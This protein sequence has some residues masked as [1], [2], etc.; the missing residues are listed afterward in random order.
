MEVHRGV[1]SAALL[2]LLHFSVCLSSNQPKNE[3]LFEGALCEAET[4]RISP[5]NFWQLQE[6]I[7]S[8]KHIILNGVEFRVYGSNGFV[9]IE[10]VSNLT[11]S[12]GESG[13]LIECSPQSIFGLHLKNTTNVTL[14][15]LR[16]RNCGS[17]IPNNFVFKYVSFS[18]A[19][20]VPVPSPPTL[21]N[22]QTCLLIEDSRDTT[23][24]KIDVE[25]SPALAVTVIDFPNDE[26][27][28]TVY[29]NLRLTDC[30][31]THSGG[32]SMM[33]YGPRSVLVE[34][35]VFANSTAGIVSYYADLTVKN[36][37]VIYCKSSYLGN[38]QGMVRERLT[39]NHSSLYIRQHDLHFDGGQVLF[40]GE[41]LHLQICRNSR[42]SISENSVVVFTNPSLTLPS[43]DMWYSTIQLNNSTLIFTEN[44]AS[45]IPLYDVFAVTSSQIDMTNQSSVIITKSSLTH[46]G[47][48]LRVTGSS[49]RMAQDCHL[50][51]TDNV[52]FFLLSFSNFSSGG[53]VRVANNSNVN[54]ALQIVYS[55]V[56]FGRLEVAGNRADGAGGGM[57]VANSELFLTATTTFSDN[58]A[59]NGGALSLVSS[60]V[61]ISPSADVNFTR[62]FAYGVGGAIF[63]SSQRLRYTC[64]NAFVSCSIQ[65][66]LDDS[67]DSCQLFSVTFNQ[68]RAGIAGNAIYGGRK[69]PTCIPTSRDETC[70]S[71]P[72]PDISDIFT[73]NGVN[74]S[75]DLSSFTSDATRVC[76]CENGIPDCYEVYKNVTVH[77]GEHFNLS[78]VTVGY[79][80]GTVQ[81]SVFARGRLSTSVDEGY[82]WRELE[83]KY[84]QEIPGLE[85]QDVEYSIAS[86]RDAEQIALAVSTESFLV[87]PG[88]AH[89]VV[90]S[91][92]H[93]PFYSDAFEAFSHMP[94]YV[95]LTLL[96]CP[97][98]FQLVRGRCICHKILLDNNIDTCSFYNGTVLI[99]RPASYWIGLPNDTNSS[100]L[101]HPH[102]PFDYC[103]SQDTNINEETYDNQCQHQRSGVL[104]GS[105]REGLSMILGSSECKTCSNVYLVSLTVFILMGVALV[106]LVTLLNMTVSV[107]TLNGL[108]LFA[109]FL[110]A[111]KTAFL[112]PITPGSSALV[113]FLS[114]FIAWLNLDL[115]IPMCFFDGLTTYVKTWL[116]FVFPLYI[117]AL[118]GAIIIASNYSTRVTRLLG[119]NTVSVLAT[120]VLLSYTKIL[121]ILITA[122]SFTTLT[123]SQGYHSVVWLA[124]GN[125]QYFDP[126][127]AI[128]FL[129]ALLVLLLLGVPYTVTLTAAPWIQRSRFKWVSSLYNRFKPLFDA[130][131]GPYKD[132]H[133]YW[134]GMLLLARVVL[135]VL[136]SSI[137]NTNTVAGP[138]L[139]LLLLI[140]SSSALIGLTAY[141]KPYKNKLLNGLEIFHLATLLSLSSSNLYVSRIGTGT[142]PRAGIYIVLVG[143]CFLVFLG[144]CVGHVWCKVRAFPTRRR[145][146]PPVKE[147]EERYPKWQRARVRAEDERDEE[148]EE[149][150]GRTTVDGG[151]NNSGFRDSALDLASL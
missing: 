65:A 44:A 9:V 31:I 85:C 141:L 144:I 129:V 20:Q 41:N 122:F 115:G 51:L 62:N 68:N 109:N 132:S 83:L 95:A 70:Y 12:G 102:C 4:C 126:K 119:T 25:Y 113:A 22:T 11:I 77:P 130:Y 63:V 124:D 86:E 112:P 136:F 17:A 57:T 58:L 114:T 72:P 53:L 78:L 98:G 138:Q 14:T 87:K 81:G 32:G 34:R 84:S 128:L 118:V 94:V 100:I 89:G 38:G 40:F 76:F 117:L 28:D 29:P 135:I 50:S 105:C 150:T 133:R 56:H 5:N 6:M 52:G 121:R 71:C 7:G 107:G 10:N 55:R 18:C 79:G 66:L 75:S 91:V 61:Y 21:D 93:L 43:I 143:I 147:E 116:Q 125:L 82:S 64:F 19:S 131:M 23:L 151:T 1:A 106:T 2:L 92:Q 120:L 104:C 30:T 45:S 108:I 59:L 46:Y 110:Q 67:G 37:D 137:A 54:G 36:V 90:Y 103:Q 97:V 48:F 127:H 3:T 148:R 74:D 49:W 69:A 145:P 134:T 149:V 99:L 60:V 42:I 80:L 8:N 88:E 15:R 35:S 96:P 140:F 139:N 26:P 33:I 16:I 123:G 47:T 39:M 73:Y 13:T 101:I 142:G 24:S 146:E 111:N 27:M